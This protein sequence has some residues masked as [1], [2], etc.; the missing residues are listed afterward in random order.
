MFVKPANMGSSVGITKAIDRAT[1]LARAGR[2]GALRPADRVEQGINAREIEVSVLGNDD[3][4]ASV[5]GR[6]RAVERVVR[7]RGQVSRRQSEIL[8]PAPISAELAEQVRALAIRAFKAIDG[9]GL[10]RVDFLL[11]RDTDDAVLERGQHHARLHAD[12]HVRQNVGGQ[13]A[14]L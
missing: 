5:A 8:I 6:D 14:D 11:D 9:A 7:L 12:Q 1:L 2:G 10:A 13:R 3:V 4:E